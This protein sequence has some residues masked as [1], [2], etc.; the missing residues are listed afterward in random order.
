M[1]IARQILERSGD[2]VQPDPFQEHP[3]PLLGHLSVLADPILIAAG[4]GRILDYSEG[5]TE[6]FGDRPLA[7]QMID[8]LLPFASAPDQLRMERQSWQGNLAVANETRNV[9]VSVTLMPRPGGGLIGAYSVHDVSRYA[10]LSQL[11]EELLYN[12]AHEIR[13]PL[14]TLGWSLDTLAAEDRDLPD[15]DRKLLLNSSRRTARRIRAL[16]EDLLTAGSINAGRFVVSPRP[17][18][19]LEP[20]TETAEMLEP[21]L[22]ARNQ[23]LVIEVSDARICAMADPRALRQ[24]IR[25]LLTNASKY[26]P[27]GETIH[28]RASRLDDVI[29]VLVED[30]GLGIPPDEQVGIFERFYRPPSHTQKPGVGLGLAIVKGIIDAHGGSITLESAPGVG[31]VVRFVLATADAATEMRS[32]AEDDYYFI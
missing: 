4:D 10:E 31:T 3:S 32:R 13:A 27:N 30:H 21:M 1:T 7:G 23:R 22:S 25:N 11:R 8:E 9:E 17:T 15:H 12:V 18:P 19:L 5:A 16:L 20:I 26:S 29:E 28:I 24:V 14:T 2:A 6:F